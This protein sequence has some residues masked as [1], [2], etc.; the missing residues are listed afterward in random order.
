MKTII[1]VSI[2]FLFACEYNSQK[3]QMNSKYPISMIYIDSLTEM[4]LGAFPIK[5]SYYAQLIEQIEKFMPKYIILKFFFTD[6][7]NDDSLLINTLKKYN[8][9][10]TQAGV[11]SD[12]GNTDF[13]VLSKYQIANNIYNFPNYDHAWFPYYELGK[14]FAGIG[15]VNAFIEDDEFI[16]F[17]LINSL[18]NKLYPSLPLLILQKEIDE[19]I[20]ISKTEVK[21]GS[22][23][24]PI[25]SNGSFKINL[26]RPGK[27]Y[28][29]FSLLDILHNKIDGSLLTNNIIIVFI[30]GKEAPKIKTGIGE[31]RIVAEIV[32]D[33]INTAL[34]Y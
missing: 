30:N 24:I 26:S 9:V 17:N 12:N 10:F 25:N 6:K 28:K 16:E 27:L 3:D 19:K 31:P 5:R 32:A 23:K 13:N 2:F 1:F 4:E 33:A 18:N 20:E 8:N 11:I 15:F 7:T 34:G 14:N 22:V 21:V 29:S